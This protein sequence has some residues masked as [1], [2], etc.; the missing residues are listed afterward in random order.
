MQGK[1][2]KLLDNKKIVVI[3]KV[4]FQGRQ[5]I[6]W[7]NVELFIKQYV[8]MVVNIAETGDKIHIGKDFPD[9]YANSN[10]S[11]GLRGTVAK[12]KAN[13][14]QS[15]CKMIEIASNKR[16]RENL[17]IKH[18]KNAE[19]GWYRYDTRFAMPVYDDKGKFERYNSFRAELLIRHASDC[20]LY[21]Y[22]VVNIKKET[23]T[24][25]KQLP[26]G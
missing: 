25:H 12:A 8:G 22:D 15:I 23:G 26:Y 7:D 4:I 10:Y 17:K 14:A 5:H 11:M 16:Y 1:I 2:I 3:D 18:I 20:K 13:A 21:L 19:Y 24:P 6:D 9:E